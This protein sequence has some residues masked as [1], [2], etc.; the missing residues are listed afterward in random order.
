[1]IEHNLLY[2]SAFPPSASLQSENILRLE[3]KQIPRVLV[4]VTVVT[5]FNLPAALLGAL[6]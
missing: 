3:Q 1:M 2:Q 4:M 6:L 5:N